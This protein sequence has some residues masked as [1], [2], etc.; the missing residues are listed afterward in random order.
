M[1]ASLIINVI[2]WTGAGTLLIAYTLVSL[3]GYGGTSAAYQCLNVVGSALLIVNTI[4]Y[5]AYPSAFVNIVWI[6]IA[7]VSLAGSRRGTRHG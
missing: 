1:D 3:R 7:F 5:G 4:Y 2:G 6:G